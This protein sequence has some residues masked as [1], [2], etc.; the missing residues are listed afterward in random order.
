[1]ADAV[2]A[3]ARA[4]RAEAGFWA[5]T[6][7]LVRK[8]LRIEARGLET[9]AP[10][11]VFCVVVALLLAFTLPDPVAPGRGPLAE[12]VAGFL[13][14]TVLFA[15]LTGFSRTLENE[16]RDGALDSL[17][18]APLDRS[19]LFVAKALTN[20]VGV[21]A[22]EVVL[23]P[24][25]WLLFDLRLG[26][27]WAALAA[28][29]LLVD[30]GFVALGTLLSALAAQTRSREL[31]LP[32]LALPALVPVFVAAVELSADLFAGRAFDAVAARGWFGVLVAF[33]VV[34]CAVGALTFEYA[35]E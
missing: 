34:A 30:V 27:A 7:A 11:L 18:L 12:V 22:I 31:L 32:V 21:V 26:R 4:G 14:V 25:F 19:G 24:L 6:S 17:L 5:K 20:L 29:A 1:M 23:V 9:L 3:A 8:D 13:W 15:G 10:M 35:L 33:D 28:V 16:R 2:P